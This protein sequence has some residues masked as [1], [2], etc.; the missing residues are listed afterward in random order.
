MQLIF[1]M[2]INSQITLWMIPL[3]HIDIKRMNY[4][5][6]LPIKNG[7]SPH[8]SKFPQSIWLQELQWSLTKVV[9][10]DFFERQSRLPPQVRSISDK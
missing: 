8:I 10:L 5:V 2:I 4:Y 7:S 6:I 9:V 1:D 3:L